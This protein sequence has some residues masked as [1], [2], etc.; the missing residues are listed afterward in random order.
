MFDI[1]SKHQLLIETSSSER[2]DSSSEGNSDDE[3]N[4]LFFTPKGQKID[5]VIVDESAQFLTKSSKMLINLQG[6]ISHLMILRIPSEPL[7]TENF[8][9]I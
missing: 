1:A 6:R 4:D 2:G 3:D 9:N 8:T 5:D 7:P